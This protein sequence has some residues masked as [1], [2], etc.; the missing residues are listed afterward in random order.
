MPLIYPDIPVF[1]GEYR[2]LSNFYI[3]PFTFRKELYQSSEHAFQACKLKNKKH[4]DIIRL[5]IAPKDAKRLGRM[6]PL[7]DNYEDLKKNLMY[8]IL[9]KKFRQNENLSYRLGSTGE[10]KLVE[11]NTWHDNFWGDCFCP[12]C[13]GIVGQNHLGKILMQVRREYI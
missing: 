9:C 8:S 3:S 10:S 12:D 6:Y 2:F 11:G 7:I 5:T 1:F 4:R 13:K